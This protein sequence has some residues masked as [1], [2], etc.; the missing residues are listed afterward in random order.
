MDEKLLQLVI[1]VQ[2]S[3]PIGDERQQAIVTLSD[4]LLRSSNLFRHQRHQPLCGVYLDIY[5]A[6]QLELKQEIV[7]SLDGGKCTQLNVTVWIKEV[8]S[9]T[10]SKVLNEACLQ[11]L[12]LVVGQYQPQTSQ[13]Q[14][15][16]QVLI[17]AIILSDKLL[18]KAHIYDDIYEDAKNELWIW[19]YRHINTYNPCK[20]RFIPWLNFRFDMILRNYQIKKTD[21]LIQKVNAKIIREKYQ[22]TNF[23]QSINQRE[24]I[25]WLRLNAKSLIADLVTF[26][27]IALFIFLFFI[28]QLIRQK[29]LYINSLLFEIA[30]QSLPTLPKFTE[31]GEELENI[32]QPE[33]EPI[34]SE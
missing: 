20:G 25:F 11:Q 24:I 13:W 18:H 29:S 15:G 23:I 26:K 30:R 10:F 28:A 22:L 8:R 6:L 27:I 33:S 3:P 31:A 4:Y 9:R 12:A 21:P 2:T 32:P 5:Q 1:Q 16:F 19:L 14:L 34:L 7:Q 17:N